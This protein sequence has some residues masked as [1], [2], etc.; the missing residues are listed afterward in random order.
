M[1]EES[2]DEIFFFN[3]LRYFPTFYNKISE[4]LP[5]RGIDLY[6]QNEFRK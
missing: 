2:K 5:S 1:N 6:H 4:I 3:R